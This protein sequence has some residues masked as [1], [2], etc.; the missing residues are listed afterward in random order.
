MATGIQPDKGI[1]NGMKILVIGH[2]GVGKSSFINKILGANRATVGGSVTPTEHEMVHEIHHT[3]GENKEVTVYDTLG[4]GDTKTKDRSIIEKAISKM[5]SADIVL[6][7]HRLY[8]RFDKNCQMILKEM[9]RAL[10]D[11]L[12]QHTI[13]VFTCGD[14]YAIEWDGENTGM[15][16]KQ[17]MER[18]ENAVKEQMKMYLIENKISAEV[19]RD[20]PSIVTSSKKESLLKSK[21][22]W[23][24]DFWELCEK[25]CTPQAV[26]FA[27]WYKRNSGL[28][29]VAGGGT[30]GAIIVGAAGGAVAGGVLGSPI[31]PGIG[32]VAGALVGGIGGA[33]AGAIVGGA[34]GAGVTTAGL[35]ASEKIEDKKLENAK[36]ID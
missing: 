15:S 27:N 11:S 5:K 21:I 34:G 16:A 13:I 33:I 29:A 3:V 18:Q 22:E 28:V 31:V 12:M 30:A 32:T 19:V 25:R 17:H 1:K 20:I 7:C 23:T 8:A 14:Q 26:P 10:G 24:T 35:K 6:I 2:N 36:Q 4:F 9:V